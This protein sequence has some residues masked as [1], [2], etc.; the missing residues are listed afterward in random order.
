MSNR[1]SSTRKTVR[2]Q[3][4]RF[5]KAHK[6]GMDALSRGDYDALTTAIKAEKAIITEQRVTVLDAVKRTAKAQKRRRR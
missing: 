3:T 4:E 1:E 5:M 2:R 6:S